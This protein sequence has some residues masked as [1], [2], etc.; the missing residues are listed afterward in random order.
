MHVRIKFLTTQEFFLTF[1]DVIKKQKNNL[2]YFLTNV[3]EGKNSYECFSRRKDRLIVPA[4]YLFHFMITAAHNCQWNV[5][6]VA[7]SPIIPSPFNESPSESYV[8]S[9]DEILSV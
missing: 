4:R 6:H 8:F 2:I 7:M 9:W 1:H 3:I 5:G